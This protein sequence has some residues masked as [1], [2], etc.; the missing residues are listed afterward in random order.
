MN[1]ASFL[2]K[3]ARTFAERPAVS[4]GTAPC[5]TY[6]ALGTRVARL[7]GTLTQRCGLQPGDRVALAMSNSPEYIELL[8][9]VTALSKTWHADTNHPRYLERLS[10]DRPE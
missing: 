1:V 4:L 5:L 6:G 10:R 3:A 7:A 2:T 8:Y 9:A